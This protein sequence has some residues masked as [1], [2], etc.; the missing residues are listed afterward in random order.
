MGIGHI[1]P[2]EYHPSQDNP[3]EE[4]SRSTQVKP[5]SIQVEPSSPSQVEQDSQEEMQ[6]QEQSSSPQPREQDQ[7]YDQGPYTT[8]DQAQEDGLDQDKPQEEFIGHDGLKQRIKAAT[9]GSDLQ[10]DN[11]L[12]DISKGV[13]THRQ[14]PLLATICG[15]HAFVYSFEP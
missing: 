9:K 6:A 13:S 8:Q 5:S 2:C 7:G 15:H 3:N 1:L 10:V 4:D 12:G 11:I 14:L